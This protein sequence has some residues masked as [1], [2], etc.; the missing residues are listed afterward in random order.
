MRMKELERIRKR[1]EVIMGDYPEK[2][3]E[4]SE[5]VKQAEAMRDQTREAVE[6]AE[7]MEQYERANEQL[8]LAELE[9]KFAKKALEKLDG[10]P[11]MDEAEY[12]AASGD[13]DRIMKKAVEE[14]RRQ[15]VSLMDQL[16]E[17]QD[18]YLQT[19]A[20]TNETLELLDKSANI[21]QTK[22]RIKVRH[23][24]GEPDKLTPD[25]NAWKNH[26]LRFPPGE[27]A[28]LATE[29]ERDPDEPHKTHD[30]VLC[31]AWQATRAAYPR[32]NF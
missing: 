16:K 15:A 2:R 10:A 11:R 6:Q 4:L 24:Q 18:K 27:A 26:A 20:E 28:I 1:S 12:Y 30:S 21:L 32:R 19:A 8:K 23:F 22:H 9:V 5:K 31:A 3:N 17:V 13:C 7:N 14:Y 25:A 29:C